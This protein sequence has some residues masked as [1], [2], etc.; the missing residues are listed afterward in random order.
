MALSFNDVNKR[1][2]YTWIKCNDDAKAS[3]FRN[4]FTS[5]HGGKFIRTS[6]TWEWVPLEDQIIILEP[7]FSQPANKEEEKEEIKEKCWIFSDE[8]GK[9]YVTKNIQEF[10]KDNNLTRSSLYEVISGRRKSHKGFKLDKI[11]E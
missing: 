2:S 7:S 9:K 11:I 1:G 3:Y 5:K 8:S 6:N 4:M 10:C